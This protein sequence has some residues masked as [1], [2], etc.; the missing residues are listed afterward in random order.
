[1]EQS[2]RQW[3]WLPD[4]RSFG[5]VVMRYTFLSPRSESCAL[6]A[7]KKCG[8]YAAKAVQF[9]VS[10]KLRLHNA[11]HGVERHFLLC[12]GGRMLLVLKNI[13]R[14]PAGSRA[15]PL[16]SPEIALPAVFRGLTHLCSLCILHL[17][18]D[19]GCLRLSVARV[20]SLPRHRYAKYR[21]YEQQASDLSLADA[22]LS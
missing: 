9:R 21:F 20:G 13:P 10:E 1:M 17:S 18:H 2:H 11:T 14:D 19:M 22:F 12:I 4:G 16:P 8:M 15:P 6:N 5:T 7:G 3:S